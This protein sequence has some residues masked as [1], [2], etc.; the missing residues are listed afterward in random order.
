[1]TLEKTRES[2]F[3]PIH[4]DQWMERDEEMR[5]RYEEERRRRV[6][7][8]VWTSDGQ[9]KAHLAESPH[10]VAWIWISGWRCHVRGRQIRSVRHTTAKHLVI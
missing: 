5:T 4:L 10:A 6:G 3:L 1:M 9:R 2:S 8:R 7:K